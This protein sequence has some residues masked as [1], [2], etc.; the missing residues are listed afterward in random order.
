VLGTVVGL[1]MAGLLLCYVIDINFW[2]ALAFAA[3]GLLG[4][5]FPIFDF[6]SSDDASSSFDA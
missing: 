1:F 4:P 2:W 5:I 6:G 3:V